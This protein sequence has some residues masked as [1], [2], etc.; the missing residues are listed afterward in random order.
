KYANLPKGFLGGKMDKIDANFSGD[1]GSPKTWVGSVAAELTNLQAQGISFDQGLLKVVA[2]NGRARIESADF[3]QGE[4]HL[5]LRGQSQLPERTEELPRSPAVME[6]TAAAIDLGR[7]TANSSEPLSGL[8]KLD[9]K[10]EVKNTKLQ[11]TFLASA[12]TAGFRE[13]T[14]E[15][16][17]ANIRVAKSLARSTQGKPWFTDFDSE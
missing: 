8:A 7:L 5:Y 9:G 3:V 13:G 17:T 6:I 10:I 11:G 12:A 14:V 4:N 2:Q 1:L 15:S 16:V